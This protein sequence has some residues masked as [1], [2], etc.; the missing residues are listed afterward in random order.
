MD[1]IKENKITLIICTSLAIALF[2]YILL[3]I[4]VY[5]INM[6]IRKKEY[7]KSM[8]LMKSYQLI[9]TKNNGT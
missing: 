1:F 2:I 9:W 8:K 4:K 5:L 7:L 3:K 6:N